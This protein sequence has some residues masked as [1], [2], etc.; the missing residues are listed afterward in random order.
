MDFF[1]QSDFKQRNDMVVPLLISQNF[2]NFPLLKIVVSKFSPSTSENE[3]LIALC[4]KI[5]N[6]TCRSHFR[7][8]NRKPKQTETFALKKKCT[9][10][11]I[12]R[13]IFWGINWQEWETEKTSKKMAV[14]KREKIR[15]KNKCWLR[16]LENLLGWFFARRRQL[17]TSR[18]LR[19][20]F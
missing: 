12:C 5:E 9:W 4:R 20:Q 19:G 10:K 7:S 3:H 16:V 1:S 6:C 11:I 15:L 17:F 14:I 13:Y 18:G 8:I 2:I